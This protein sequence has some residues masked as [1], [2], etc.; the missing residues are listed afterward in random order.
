M[1][2]WKVPETILFT[3]GKCHVPATRVEKCTLLSKHWHERMEVRRDNGTR[4]FFLKIHLSIKIFPSTLSHLIIVIFIFNII[5][6]FNKWVPTFYSH[7]FHDVVYP[8]L[9]AGKT[10]LDPGLA[11]SFVLFLSPLATE[12]FKGDNPREFCQ[13]LF[14]PLITCLYF[15]SLHGHPKLSYG[16]RKLVSGISP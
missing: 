12:F 2:F 10:T 5:Q 1:R 15:K 14:H 11:A 16:A 7:D 6:E 4:F 3:L 8:A 13:R 9:A